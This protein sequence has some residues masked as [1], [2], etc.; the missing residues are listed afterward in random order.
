MPES[1]SRGKP[2]DPQPSQPAVPSISKYLTSQSPLSYA[3]PLCSSTLYSITREQVPDTFS[4]E[5]H[6]PREQQCHSHGFN[7]AECGQRFIR[8]KLRKIRSLATQEQTA[9][10]VVLNSCFLFFFSSSSSSVYV[11]LRWTGS[12]A[13]TPKSI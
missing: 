13:R 2:G 1:T 4:I 8:L 3:L 12:L 7:E 6:N 9:T 5:L 10:T 11:T